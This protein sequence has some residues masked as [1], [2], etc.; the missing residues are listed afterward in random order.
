MKLIHKC[1]KLTDIP[2]LTKII[3]SIGRTKSTNKLELSMTTIFNNII[4]L[5]EAHIS[6][7]SSEMTMW[8]LRVQKNS[9]H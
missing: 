2:N 4:T 6:T 8:K 7:T 3:Q 9:S 5:I 1:Q